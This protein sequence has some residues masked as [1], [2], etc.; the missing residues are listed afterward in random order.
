MPPLLFLSALIAVMNAADP[1][2]WPL[3]SQFTVS[4]TKDLSLSNS[5]NITTNSNSQILQRSIE[6]YLNEIIFTHIPDQQPT[7]SLVTSL[8]MTVKSTDESL[9]LGI[10]ESYQLNIKEGDSLLSANTIY[11]AMRGLETFSQLIVFNF[12]L[13]YYQTSTSSITDKPRFPWRGTMIDTSRHFQP[14]SEI[15]KILDGM[16]YS[17]AN[18]L[19]WHMTDIQSFPFDSRK[20][21]LFIKGAYDSDY[22]AYSLSDIAE[23]VS[24]A[25]DRGIIILNTFFLWF[26]LLI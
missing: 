10:D 25:K 13:G 20:Y 6:R 19:H 17:K 15:K 5:F 12:S 14:I 21:P 8:A 7:N 11:G 26:I 3:P 9:Q 22:Q 1:L 2:I 16:S 24:Y 18:I 4:P 23:I